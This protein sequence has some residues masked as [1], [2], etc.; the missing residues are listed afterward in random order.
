MRL[1]KRIAFWLLVAAIVAFSLLPFLYA[2]VTS[3]RAGSELFTIAYWP[4]RPTLW[5]Y[6]AVFTQQP[7]KPQHSELGHRRRSSGCAVPRARHGDGGLRFRSHRLPRA[8]RAAC[9][10]P[11]GIDVP[12]G[13]TCF[14]ACSS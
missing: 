14:P 1:A 9:G 12:A 10:D 2:V 6:A 3:L 5:F 8:E 11:C 7:F 13:C 4:S